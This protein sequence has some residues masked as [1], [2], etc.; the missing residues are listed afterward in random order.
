MSEALAGVGGKQEQGRSID[1][2]INAVKE[3]MAKREAENSKSKGGFG[4]GD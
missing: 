1:D 2:R 4:I 3:R